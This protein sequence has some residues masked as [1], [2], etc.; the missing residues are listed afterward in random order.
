MKLIN[1][2]I[3]ILPWKLKRIIL[4]KF[5][6][7]HIDKTAKIGFSYIFPKSLY[8]E[9]NTVI[10]NFCVCINIDLL[11]LGK[12]SRIGRGNWITGF[13]S[14][15]NSQF[16]KHQQDRNP[17]LVIGNDSLIL[18]NHHFDCTNQIQIGDFTTIA[19]YNTQFLTHSI[20]IHKNIQD[21]KPINIGDY[22]FIG[23]K[24]IFLGGSAI[25]S[26]SVTGAGAVIN[27]DLTNYGEYSLFGGVPAKFIKRLN[28][29]DL[30]FKRNVGD[31]K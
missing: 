3:C 21:S 19:G 1:A 23:T 24:N 30:Y 16:F 22:C 5:Y 11:K 26:K 15:T 10:R 9:K 20:N 4:I 17:Q 2:I 25:P 14:G 8:M 18:K 28:C 31:V 12:N 13:P 6:G 27:K 29:D 7:Y